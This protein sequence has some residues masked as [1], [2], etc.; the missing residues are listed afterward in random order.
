MV[1]QIVSDVGGKTDEYI[2]TFT[3]LRD[4]LMSGFQVHA[5]IKIALVLQEMQDIGVSIRLFFVCRDV[6]FH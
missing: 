5:E 6:I 4:A 2:Q 3:D 1:R